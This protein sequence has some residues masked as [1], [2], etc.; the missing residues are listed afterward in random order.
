MRWGGILHGWCAG[1]TA[2]APFAPT[3]SPT[4][5]PG[6]IAPA[7]DVAKDVLTNNSGQTVIAFVALIL[8]LIALAGQFSHGRKAEVSVRFAKTPD[9]KYRADRLVIINHGAASAKAVEL[10]LSLREGQQLWQP[11]DDDEDPFPIA[12]L[13]PGASFYV[14]VSVGPRS[15]H[16]ALATVTW[17]DKRFKRQKWQSTVSTAGQI[18][19]GASLENFHAGKEQERMN[20]LRSYG[21]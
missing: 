2:S 17:K 21:L 16:F 12:V 6:P 5:T 14:D 4:P 8:S 13:A 1:L 9:F 18:L 10:S 3:P 11:Y 15:E 20:I 7:L 19:G